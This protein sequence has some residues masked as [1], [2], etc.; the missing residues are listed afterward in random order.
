MIENVLTIGG[1]DPSGGAGIQADLKAFSANCVYGMSVIT[2]LTAQNTVGVFS[3]HTPPAKFLREQFASVCEDVPPAAIKIGMLSNLEVVQAVVDS[4]VGFECKHIILDPVMVSSTGGSLLEPA[5]IGA[6]YDDLLPMAT[7]ITPNLVEVAF[8]LDIQ[9][10]KSRDEM[11]A[12]AMELQLHTKNH[13]LLKG[14]HLDAGDSPDLLLTKTGSE[15]WFETRRIETKNTHGTG[16][17]LS[18]AMVAHLARNGGEI[19]DAVVKAKKYV[20]DAL[21][22]SSLLNVGQGAGPT[23]HFVNMWPR[24]SNIVADVDASSHEDVIT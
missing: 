5:A 19:L 21:A 23:H 18:A 13:I 14:G 1:S 7:V 24:E 20:T 6:L 15:H 9:V 22:A 10:P 12:A 8:L 2:A 11:R 4:L 17:T 16:C 3:T